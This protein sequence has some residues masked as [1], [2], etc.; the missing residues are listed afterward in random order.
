MTASFTELV[1]SEID[2]YIKNNAGVDVFDLPQNVG[3][4]IGEVEP[5][6]TSGLDSSLVFI[7]KIS[8]KHGKPS[9]FL[10]TQ[11]MEVFL[12]IGPKSRT[13]QVNLCLR[14]KK[15]GLSFEKRKYL[16]NRYKRKIWAC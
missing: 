11:V 16:G 2:D 5:I 12:F 8:P 4:A 7:L 6:F 9:L 1:I 13:I 10:F 3:D 14:R 15:G